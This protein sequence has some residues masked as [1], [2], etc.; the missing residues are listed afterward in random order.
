MQAHQIASD[1]SAAMM[2][3]EDD[4]LESFNRRK[5]RESKERLAAVKLA[6]DIMKTPNGMQIANKVISKDMLKT[7]E[8]D[9]AV[10]SADMRD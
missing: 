8:T 2:K 10:P 4:R 3:N 1:H 6:Q 9:E 7:L 5:D